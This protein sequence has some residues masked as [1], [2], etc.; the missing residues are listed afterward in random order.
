[1]LAGFLRFWLTKKEPD[2]PEIIHRSKSAREIQV[3]DLESGNTLIVLRSKTSESFD[4]YYSLDREQ[5]IEFCRIL[6]AR[7]ESVIS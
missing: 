4:M 2:M 3:Y 5:L 6:N 1:M 7:L